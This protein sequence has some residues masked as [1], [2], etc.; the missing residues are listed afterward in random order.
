MNRRNLLKYALLPPLAM[1]PQLSMAS[2]EDPGASEKADTD[3]PE[4]KI[5]KVKAIATAPSGVALVV[6][7]VETNEPGLFDADLNIR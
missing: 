4:I 2:L 6:V 3:M 1:A 5:T 7:R